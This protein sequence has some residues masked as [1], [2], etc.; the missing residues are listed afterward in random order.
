MSAHCSFPYFGIAPAFVRPGHTDISA[1]AGA[2]SH[3]LASL[4]SVGDRSGQGSKRPALSRAKEDSMHARSGSRTLVALAILSGLLTAGPVAAGRTLARIQGTVKDPLGDTVSRA[5]VALIRGRTSIRQTSTA[6]DGTFAFTELPAGNYQVR[7]V[8]RGFKPATTPLISL[9]PNQSFRVELHLQ[10]GLLKEHVVVSATGS[11]LPES[12]VGASVSVLSGQDLHSLHKLDV[13]DAL[14]F[15][16]GVQV[17]QESQRG[18][19]ASV[20]I[21]GGDDTFNKVLVDGIPVND[22]GGEFDFSN[23]STSGVNEV[24]V[25]RGPDSILYGS[26]ALAGVISITTRQGSTPT[27]QFTYS[28]DGGNFHSYR[29]EASVG[30]VFHQFDYFSDFM[31][32]DTQNSLPNNSFHNATYTG[33]FGWKP[34]EG[35]SVRLAIHHDA[36]GLGVSNALA[37]YALPDDSFQRQQDTDFSL[38]AQDQT[39]S[40]WHNMLRMTSAH[41]HYD[42]DT[43]APA[44]IPVSSPSLGKD[45]LGEPVKICGANGYC[46]SG[47]GILDYGG[48]YPMVF[49]SLTSVR[50][51]YGQTDY[52]FRPDLAATG[53]FTYINETGSAQSSGAAASRIARNNFD[54]F[55]ESHGNLDRRLF[56]TAGIGLE[57]NAVFGFAATPRASLAYYLRRP[58]A[59]SSWG[60]T[61]L[62]FNFGTGIKEPSLLDQESSLYTLVSQAPS[63]PGLLAQYGI[64]PIGAERS[65][66]LDAGVEQGFSNERFQLGATYFR[67]RF[68]D[69]IDFVP[70]SALPALGVPKTIAAEAPFGA[71]IN[72]DSFRSQGGELD[73]IASLSSNLTFHAT[74]T[75]LDAVV[76][77]SFSSSAL[78]PAFNPAFPNLPI[79][80]D[81]P[82]VGGRP[83]RR[84][85]DSG[86]FMLAYSRRRF[87]V[88]LNGYIAGRSDDSTYLVD[89]DF[90]DTM[91]LP[92]HD[93]LAGYQLV[94]LSGWYSLDRYVRLYTSMSNV[95]DEHYQAAFGY[96]ALPFTFRAGV[97]FSLGG[98][99]PR[100]P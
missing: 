47:Q 29:Q 72:S 31:R 22:I 80:A 86:S 58:S 51:V 95:L 32:F 69:L 13:L 6:N 70:Q 74:Y 64:S 75:Y 1:T 87:G 40:R 93:L 48:A 59:V 99:E 79:G 20:F 67:E 81:A 14:R 63:G 46:T 54:G 83:F 25:F 36:T 15:V 62:D 16:P 24:E 65:T 41:I 5:N 30:G 44:G 4:D 90:G 82:L 52:A 49:N 85:S 66:S 18:S 56:G 96:P 19:V 78:F 68:Y 38:T 84:P 53:G 45:Y 61:K 92:N 34:A 39:T 57:S 26:D 27:P 33:N 98:G 97:R 3:A 23:L 8:A 89:R 50:S 28:A 55:L 77:R 100:R 21:R 73:F 94:G 7:I 35:A 88:N 2:R 37:L 43:P 9:R 76:T 12:Q 42:F 71:D 11:S 91:L 10:I 60:H 17:V